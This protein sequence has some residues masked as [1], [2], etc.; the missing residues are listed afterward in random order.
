MHVHLAF[1]HLQEFGRTVPM[2]TETETKEEGG[3]LPTQVVQISHGFLMP[4]RESY[5]ADALRRLFLHV[6]GPKIAG[7]KRWGCAS[8]VWLTFPYGCESVHISQE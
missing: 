7:R 8:A 5:P 6:D 4:R 1:A 2:F 3:A